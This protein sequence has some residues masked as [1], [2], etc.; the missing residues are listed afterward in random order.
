MPNRFKY[1]SILQ[2]NNMANYKEAKENMGGD[3]FYIK[4]I[5]QK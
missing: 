2:R 1:P 4:L 3:D 5:W